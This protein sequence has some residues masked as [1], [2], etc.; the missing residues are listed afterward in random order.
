[1]STNNI[2]QEFVA[3]IRE[4]YQEKSNSN[5]DNFETKIAELT[6]WKER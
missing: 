5:K 3:E 1:V 4:E 6:M 2:D